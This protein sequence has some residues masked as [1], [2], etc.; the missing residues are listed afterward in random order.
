MLTKEELSIQEVIF[1]IF[2]FF[3]ETIVAR[4]KLRKRLKRLSPEKRKKYIDT[5]KKHADNIVVIIPYGAI[6]NLGLK[7]R[8]Q[9][10]SWPIYHLTC[11]LDNTKSH[12]LRCVKE[13]ASYVKNFTSLKK[14]NRR[15]V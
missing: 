10:Q 8:P 14:V 13:G 7:I 12:F 3:E 15:D 2:N 9:C 6:E 11:M 5:C 1:H 4:L